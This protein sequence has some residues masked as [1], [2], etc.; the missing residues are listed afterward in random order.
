ML[1][2]IAHSLSVTVPQLFAEPSAGNGIVAR[3]GGRPTLRIDKVGSK[4]E[5]LVPTGPGH[6][7]EGNLH[8]LAPGGGSEG[9]L[10]HAGEEMGFVI[11]G[12]IELVVNGEV[13]RLEAGDSFVFRS[14]L[15]HSYRNPGRSETKVIWVSTPPTF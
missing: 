11:A 14:E 3:G 2:R 1:H 10:A 7:L 12:S 4:L 5:R 9:T 6:L 13:Y 15:P 8:I